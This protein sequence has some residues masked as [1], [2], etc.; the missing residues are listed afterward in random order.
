MLGET[1][2]PGPKFKDPSIR[3][4]VLVPFFMG[5]EEQ[6]VGSVTTMLTSEANYASRSI[7]PPRVE[8]LK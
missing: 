5:G 8:I 7:V 4:R 6:L 1:S 2:V 3:V